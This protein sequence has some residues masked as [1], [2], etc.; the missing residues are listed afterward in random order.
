MAVTTRENAPFFQGADKFMAPDYPSPI[1]VGHTTYPTVTNAFV[2][3][4]RPHDDR[5]LNHMAAVSPR[6]AETMSMFAEARPDWNDIRDRVM[7][8]LL[9]AKFSVQPMAQMLAEREGDIVWRTTNDPH[10]G[11][12]GGVGENV[13][14]RMLEDVRSEVRLRDKWKRRESV[15]FTG[16]RPSTRRDPSNGLYPYEAKGDWTRLRC[17]LTTLL[18]NLANEM[19]PL[20]VITGGAQGVD[21]TAFWAALTAQRAGVDIRNR[22]YA[23]STDQPSRWSNRKDD[24][25][26]QDQYYKMLRLADEVRYCYA[27]H[28]KA[29]VPFGTMA[30][31]RNEAMADDTTG[32][33]IAVCKDALD[34]LKP[35]SGTANAI[36]TA[37]RRHMPLIHVIPNDPAHVKAVRYAPE[38]LDQAMAKRQ[39]VSIPAAPSDTGWSMA[40]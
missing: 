20:D 23:P 6:E 37:Q 4:M 34:A 32:Y 31:N 19:G 25:F 17:A 40:Y 38:Q 24:I 2:A 11:V 33:V 29:N 9:Q 7:E 35:H 26:S 30:N 13:L 28:E 1:R 16:H 18:T 15:M 12:V 14:G 21:Q 27:D 36:R 3:Q 8:A 5:W 39:Q 10:F 22:V